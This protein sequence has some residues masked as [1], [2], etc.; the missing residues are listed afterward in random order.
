[1]GLHLQRERLADWLGDDDPADRS[2]VLDGFRERAGVELDP[3]A[4]AV[5]GDDAESP[6]VGSYTTYDIFRLCLQFVTRG[7]YEEELAPDDDLELAALQ[8]FRRDLTPGAL[9]IPAATHILD[10]GDTDTIFVPARFD[11]PYEDGER[12]IASL[13]AAVEALE[14][15]ASGL[16]FNLSSEPDGE[17]ADDGRW[18]PSAT[19]KNVARILHRF[20]T[21]HAATGVALS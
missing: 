21:K 13:P 18:L 11:A 17:Y 7:D 5:D 6:R 2:R 15:F 12:Y 14:G 19:A 9:D 8:E 10:S 3:D 4:G 16:K 1:M 20:L